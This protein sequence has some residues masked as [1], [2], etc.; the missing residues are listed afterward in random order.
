MLKKIFLKNNSK[1]NNYSTGMNQNNSKKYFG[2]GAG[3][4]HLKLSFLKNNFI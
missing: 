4:R 2:V 1:K 3:R